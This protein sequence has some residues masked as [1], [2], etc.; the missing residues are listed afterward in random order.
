MFIDMTFRTFFREKK[1]NGT[2]WGEMRKT[3]S[4]KCNLHFHPFQNIDKN[5]L[6]K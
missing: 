5:Y 3:M 6:C 4:A 1:S 2:F